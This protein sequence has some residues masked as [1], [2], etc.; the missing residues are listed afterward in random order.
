MSNDN[1]RDTQEAAISATGIPPG[2]NSESAIIASLSPG[3]YTAVVRGQNNG[4]GIALVEVYNLDAAT[5]AR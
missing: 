3:N 4:T 2:N 1:W 5:T